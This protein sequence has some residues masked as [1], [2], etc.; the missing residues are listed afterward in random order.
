MNLALD[1][2]P[3]ARA[4]RAVGLE[5]IGMTKVFGSMTALD[6][7]SEARSRPA[8]CTHSSARTAP[9]SRRWSSA[10]WAFTSR[11]GARC[12]STGTETAIHSPRDAHAHGIGMVYQ[13][14]TLV[15][16]DVRPREPRHQPA[17]TSAT[18]HRLAEGKA[19]SPRRLPR[20][21]AVQGAARR[22]GVGTLRRARSR[23]LRSSSSSISTSTS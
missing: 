5:T 1:T 23:S 12:W 18:G 21:D 16:T 10:S 13:H 15:P 19:R 4:Q 3:H 6:D 7:V 9:A 8:R 22:A 2:V 17:R 11:P 14:F 20:P